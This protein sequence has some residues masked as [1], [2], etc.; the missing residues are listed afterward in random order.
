[1]KNNSIYIYIIYEKIWTSILY[2]IVVYIIWSLRKEKLEVRF[3]NRL[4]IIV[5]REQ[6]ERGF[7]TSILY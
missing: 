6:T 1:M 4:D 3:N 5:R 2:G 7:Y